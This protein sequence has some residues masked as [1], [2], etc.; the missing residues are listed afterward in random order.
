LLDIMFHLPDNK[1]LQKVV[2]TRDCIEG[3]APAIQINA[4]RKAAA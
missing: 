4:E 1:R 2:I 3:R